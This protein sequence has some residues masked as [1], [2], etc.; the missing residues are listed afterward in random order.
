MQCPKCPL[1]PEMETKTHG[2]HITVNRCADCG[3]IFALPDVLERIKHEWFADW[4]DYGKTKQG[5]VFNAIKD[6]KCPECDVIMDNVVDEKQKH[7]HLER[8]P[9]CEG[10]FFDAGEM[11]DWKYE[12]WMD[13]VKGIIAKFKRS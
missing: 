5:K 12:T 9:G 2:R 1:H 11:T 4:M 3:G 7:L 10:V 13:T 6:I 8:C